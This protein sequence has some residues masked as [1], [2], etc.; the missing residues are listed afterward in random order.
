LSRIERHRLIEVGKRSFEVAKV[1]IGEAAAG[2]RQRL[3]FRA[4]RQSSLKHERA[5]G[6][7][8]TG[9]SDLTAI[10]DGSIGGASQRRKKSEDGK[11]ERDER[12]GHFNPPM[13]L[14]INLAI[15]SSAGNER[16]AGR[17]IRPL[18]VK[19]RRAAPKR[20]G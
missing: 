9:I 1:R 15:G 11:R 3:V 13:E 17:I 6:N 19:R 2:Q 12:T 5:A 16:R 18:V 10:C 4:D 20:R 14:K 7:G 8:A